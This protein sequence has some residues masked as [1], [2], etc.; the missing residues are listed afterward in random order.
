M[1]K[2]FIFNIALNLLIVAA[3]YY[4]YKAYEAG[5]IL[6]SGLA[7]ALLVVFIFLKRVLFKKVQLDLKKEGE[8]RKTEQTKK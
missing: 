1:T 3:V 4:G 2:N 6:I 5:N 8:R 7:I